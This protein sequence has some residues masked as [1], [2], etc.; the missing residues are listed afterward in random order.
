MTAVDWILGRH[1]ANTEEREQKVGPF[2]GVSM[3]GLD[4]L[5]SSAYGPEALLTVLLPLGALGISA[6]LPI[7]AGIVVLLLAVAASY[8]QIVK[9]Y[10]NGGGAYAV[11][12]ENLGP[13]AAVVA[14]SA[15][16]LD[17][18][19]AVAV[20]ISAGVGAIISALPALQPYTLSLSLFIL[21]AIGLLNLRGVKESSHTLMIPTY[22]FVLSLGVVLVGGALKAFLAGGNPQPV[23]PVPTE[24]RSV[25]QGV[26][27]WWL[28]ARAFSSGSSALTGVEAV[29]NATTAFRE[30]R[31]R[32][33]NR[34]LA[35]IVFILGSFLVGIASLSHLYGI[36]ATEPGQSGY[37]SV[38]SQL[39][40]A[41]YG[42][43]TFYYITMAFGTAILCLSANTGFADFPRV[44][45]IVAEDGYL[46]QSLGSRGRRLV[47]SNGIIVL[48]VLA[49][50]L[51]F[52]FGGITDRLI[53]LFAIGAFLSF[54]LSQAGMAVH[55][56]RQG[57][58]GSLSF[59]L[60]VVGAV[61]T[62]LTA[63]AALVTRF[64]EGAWLTALFLPSLYLLMVGI[65][66]HHL[67]VKLELTCTEPLDLTRP[68]PVIAV[69]PIKNWNLMV[70]K[71]LRFSM[72]LSPHV[73][74]VH[75]QGDCDK[76]LALKDAWSRFVE[77]PLAEQGF[78][79]PKLHMLPCPYRN[80]L[81]NILNFI[82]RLNDQ[83][84]GHRIAIVVPHMIEERWYQ[85]LLHAQRATVLKAALLF[86]RH[87][88]VVVV[89]VPWFVGE[90]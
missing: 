1:L 25:T 31:V 24:A 41:V 82:D 34:T 66:R 27:T 62:G 30:P 20:G 12:K 68:E 4:A 83:Y 75:A 43:G 63:L 87:P 49:G 84:P 60:N 14:A 89:T 65:K 2:A 19:L 47:F 51:L 36:G 86:R 37:E 54:T 77:Q 33:S 71:A 70:R 40:R 38:I 74:A 45:K 78:Q 28:V 88:N 5:G 73:I 7:T 9:A 23:E 80:L 58:A 6:V 35:L 21:L 53:P 50:V 69:V 32:N 10:P 76:D 29:S 52:V 16:I 18:T 67:K 85:N 8:K 56:A 48:S 3:V 72:Q 39:T 57:Q 42:R 90:T 46:P 81:K 13:R 44:C 22:G 15:L 79:T 61:L 64:E 59:I 17:Y 11:A 26:L 55:W